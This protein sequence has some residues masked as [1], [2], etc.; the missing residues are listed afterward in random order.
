M[1]KDIKVALNVVRADANIPAHLFKSS[2]P[3]RDQFVSE[4]ING[5]ISRDQFFELTASIVQDIGLHDVMR[6]G[7]E[8]IEYFQ[9][10]YIHG[11]VSPMSLYKVL[12]YLEQTDKLHWVFE[13]VKTTKA[14]ELAKDP[15]YR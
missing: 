6:R 12:G 1:K 11:F 8:F 3:K 10:D 9:Q 15:H 13:L 5:N 4:Y 14:D 2:L 7:R